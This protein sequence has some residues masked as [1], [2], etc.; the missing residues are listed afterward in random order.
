M[1]PEMQS[2]FGRRS[3][4]SHSGFTLIEL[5]I[6]MA[7]LAILSAIAIPVYTDYVKQGKLVEATNKLSSIRASMEQYYQDNR[8]YTQTDPAT[9]SYACVKTTTTDFVYTCS[10]GDDTVTYTATATG[11][12]QMNGFVYTIDQDG[13]MATTG[14]PSGWTDSSGSS[15]NASCWI[16]RKGG[17]C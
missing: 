5:M 1:R 6:A 15:S 7:V 14:L 10:A 17:S 13:A 16:T 12:N 4:E 8:T 2:S 3:S 9:A 11:Q